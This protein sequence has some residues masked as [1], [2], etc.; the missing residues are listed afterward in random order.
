MDGLQ[1]LPGATQFLEWLCLCGTFLPDAVYL[2]TECCKL[3]K[4]CMLMLLFPYIPLLAL[5]GFCFFLFYHT[6]DIIS[7]DVNMLG[8]LE[9]VELMAKRN[10]MFFAFVVCHLAFCGKR[11]AVEEIECHFRNALERRLRSIF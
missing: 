11:L 6:M 1:L 3:A 5:Q 2:E 8:P 7:M 4:Q 9:S 10:L